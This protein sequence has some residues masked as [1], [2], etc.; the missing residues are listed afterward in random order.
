MYP[1][2]PLSRMRTA[3]LAS[4]SL[5]SLPSWELQQQRQSSQQQQQQQQRSEH[6]CVQQS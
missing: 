6:F 4:A 5:I 1:V 3:S 2:L